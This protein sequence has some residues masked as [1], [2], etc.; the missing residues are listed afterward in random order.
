MK[1]KT[2][3]ISELQ[4]GHGSEAVDN[5]KN[6]ARNELVVGLQW[7]HGSEAVDNSFNASWPSD[8]MPA[9]QWGHGSEAVDNWADPRESET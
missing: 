6:L 3:E 4:W 5:T 1:K 8:P 7:G 9:L 2:I